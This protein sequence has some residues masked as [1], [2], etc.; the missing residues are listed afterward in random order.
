MYVAAIHVI[1]DIRLRNVGGRSVAFSSIVAKYE[2]SPYSVSSAQN[3]F[4]RTEHRVLVG[5]TP[6]PWAIVY[7]GAHLVLVAVSARNE[8]F[9]AL[10]AIKPSPFLALS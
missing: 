1:P 5:S 8:L 9:S 4:T 7:S 2:G 3:S 6:Q 10:Y